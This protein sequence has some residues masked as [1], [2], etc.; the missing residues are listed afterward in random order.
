MADNFVEE[1]NKGGRT[2]LKLGSETVK[3][4]V[5]S[6]Y[7]RSTTTGNVEPTK[8][9]HRLAH[10]VEVDEKNEKYKE[11][12]KQN[13]G[14]DD[15]NGIPFTETSFGR[16]YILVGYQDE[17]GDMIANPNASDNLQKDYANYNQGKDTEL[18]RSLLEKVNQSNIDDATTKN[19]K[20][21][22]P[23]YYPF[24]PSDGFGGPPVKTPNTATV[25]GDTGVLKT[26]PGGGGDGDGDG[27]KDI[28][29]SPPSI[30][31][32]GPIAANSTASGLEGLP[33]KTVRYPD[34]LISDQT[35]YLKIGIRAY[36]AV[37]E[38]FVRDRSLGILD[39]A[40]G[41]KAADNLGYILLPIPANIQD[42][43]AVKYT[44]GSMD[45]LSAEA[46]KFATRTIGAGAK[47]DPIQ[48]LQNAFKGAAEGIGNF[49]E[50]GTL[51]KLAT[52][53]LAAEALNA[54][55]GVSVT[56][57][58]L[59]ARGSGGIVNPN[60]ELLFNGVTL[61][62]FRFSFKLTP[63]NDTESSSIKTIIKVF[64]KNM[65]PK[66]A[67]RAQFLATP[68]IFDLQY[69]KGGDKHPFLN[70]FKSCALTDMSVN[71]TGD[72]TYA[73]YHDGTPVSMIMDL[74]FRELEAVYDEDYDKVP[75][76]EG[77]G[78]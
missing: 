38:D 33:G 68:N 49:T 55:P 1:K 5:V 47:D 40:T 8:E 59:I 34:A 61:R 10:Y 57:D 25:T 60:M 41:Q 45:A 21:G 15:V 23:G 3:S 69:M 78:F 73:T 43:N 30:A 56:R 51:Q 32:F 52:N 39:S 35:D 62:T 16:K 37:G 50:D 58:Q 11:I 66:A 46:A 24:I 72:G 6:N 12:F 22:I 4:L 64:K 13:Q 74:T 54:L 36:K 67:K 28:D 76:A 19:E 9:N 14:I 18:T 17:N 42:T 77:V 7:R 31:S 26:P 2:S 53:S 44:D 20:A 71:Y 48:K 65:A 70:S 27:D 29:T 63:R 75:S